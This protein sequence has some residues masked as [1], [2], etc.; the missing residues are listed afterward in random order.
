M[1]KVQYWAHYRVHFHSIMKDIRAVLDDE[2]P[3]YY[4]EEKYPHITIHPRFQFDE[5][6][7]ERFRH[8]VYEI[9]P[10]SIQVKINGFYYYPNKHQPMVICLDIDTNIQ[11]RS[12][13]KH[14]CDKISKKGG[15]NVLNT[16]PPHITVY[17]SKDT[18]SKYRKIPNNVN[19]I[20]T[21]C[22]KIGNK[23]L[24]IT[25]SETELKFERASF[26]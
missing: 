26:Q 7:I 2:I 24:P 1:S 14:I 25:V 18:G 16:A 11:F 23:K 19:Q 20:K 22:K 12:L 15:K 9:F 6:E 10:T 8:Y 5:S 4:R 13:Q 21:R 3:S 17:K